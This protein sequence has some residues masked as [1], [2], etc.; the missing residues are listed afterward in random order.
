MKCKIS[1]PSHNKKE[2][3]WEITPEGRVWPCCYYAN[4]WEK[5]MTLMNEQ[6]SGWREAVSLFQDKPMLEKMKEDPNWNH[7]DHNNLDDIIEDPILWEHIYYPGWES[8]NP[9]HIC[10]INCGQVYDKGSGTFHGKS[11]LEADKQIKDYQR[12]G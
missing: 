10:E 12:G 1:C 3:E 11:E 8:D 2:R 4:V 7:L 5:R 9:P 6:I